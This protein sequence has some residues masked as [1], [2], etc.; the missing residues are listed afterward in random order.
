MKNVDEVRDWLFEELHR[1]RSGETTP[2]ASNA[3]A[4]LVGK[5]LYSAKLEID[6]N[7]TAGLT[8]SIPFLNKSSQ[9]QLEKK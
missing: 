9:K 6:Y 3:A 2:A 8:P 5:L 4:N 7:K 1:L